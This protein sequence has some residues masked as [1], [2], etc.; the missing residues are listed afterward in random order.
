LTTEAIIS[1][2]T[3]M[4]VQRELAEAH[5]TLGV[6]LQDRKQWDGAMALFRKAVE[7]QPDFAEAVNN[8]EAAPSLREAA[9]NEKEAQQ[10]LSR[11]RANTYVTELP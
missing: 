5:N 10:E 1:F 8:L 4:R 3:A 11:E 2:L 7:L 6:A 9:K